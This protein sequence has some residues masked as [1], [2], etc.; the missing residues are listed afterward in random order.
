[1]FNMNLLFALYKQPNMMHQKRAGSSSRIQ[2]V[3][4]SH[5]CTLIF[6]W[7]AQCLKA[8]VVRA[9]ET[10]QETTLE[11]L[12]LFCVQRNPWQK[13]ISRGTGPSHAE[14]RRFFPLMYRFGV[15]GEWIWD[16]IAKELASQ[17]SKSTQPVNQQLANHL[18]LLH[19]FPNSPPETN[20]EALDVTKWIFFGG[21]GIQCGIL[22]SRPNSCGFRTAPLLD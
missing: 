19:L 17:L 4:A 6:R 13:G 9:T 12:K 8:F 16:P 2:T 1:M 7:T 15:T 3:F 11:A 18:H 20:I 22:I 14:N 21:G 5:L 10:G